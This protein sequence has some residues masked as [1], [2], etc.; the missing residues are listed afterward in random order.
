MVLWNQGKLKKK[1]QGDSS[2]FLELLQIHSSLSLE[3]RQERRRDGIGHL[4]STPTKVN[5]IKQR[6]RD[7]NNT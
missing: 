1:V 6:Q 5:M 4:P 7:C 2:L 3:C